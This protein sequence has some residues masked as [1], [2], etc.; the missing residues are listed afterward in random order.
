MSVKNITKYRKETKQINKNTMEKEKPKK[1][2]RPGKHELH[3]RRCRRAA[4]EMAAE[5]AASW[6]GAE[7]KVPE[8]DPVEQMPKMPEIWKKTFRNLVRWHR[9][10]TS[11]FCGVLSGDEVVEEEEE[12][13]DEEEE[14]EEK[15]DEEKSSQEGEYEV[16]EEM[17]PETVDNKVD[18]DQV[19][20]DYL[21]FLEVTRKHQMELKRMRAEED[22]KLMQKHA[23]E[24]AALSISARSGN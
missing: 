4:A 16:N 18:E 10:Q 23:K 11:Y 24:L 15:K 3:R 8:V 5:A 6:V 19:D 13:K 22:Q 7:L 17:P 2:R 14:E 1:R 12:K 20:A 9:Q 21:S